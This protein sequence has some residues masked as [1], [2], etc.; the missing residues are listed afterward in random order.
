MLKIPLN[1]SKGLAYNLEKTIVALSLHK[2]KFD[3]RW[4]FLCMD[5]TP[6]D[7]NLA[8]FEC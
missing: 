5:K 7:V 8:M 4:Y 6:N 1:E 2:S 3:V